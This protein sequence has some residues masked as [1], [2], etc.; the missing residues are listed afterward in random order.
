MAQIK[1]THGYTRR[2]SDSKASSITP[3]T[4]ADR[5]IPYYL[6]FENTSHVK[7]DA[8][9]G[10]WMEGEREEKKDNI[11]QAATASGGKRAERE[12]ERGTARWCEALRILY[13]AS[14]SA[15]I[16]D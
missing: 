6:D 15:P 4:L 10:D 16:A 14:R 3:S 13:E 8:V 1:N 11:W 12:R 9:T 2:T 7:C 5:A